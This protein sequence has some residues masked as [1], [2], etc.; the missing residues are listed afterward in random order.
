MLT[1]K[2]YFDMLNCIVIPLIR[3]TRLSYD[4]KVSQRKIYVEVRRR[5]SSLCED[6][7]RICVQW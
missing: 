2:I 6:I 3:V 7:Q 1:F 5:Y 4:E